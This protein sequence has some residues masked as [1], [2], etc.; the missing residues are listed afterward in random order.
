M[1]LFQ[2]F[3]CV[4]VMVRLC[5]GRIG[6]DVFDE[7]CRGVSS[8]DDSWQEVRSTLLLV[9]PLEFCYMGVTNLVGGAI[10]RL[11]DDWLLGA[12]GRSRSGRASVLVSAGSSRSR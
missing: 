2:E 7:S 8:G 1:N 6:V 11:G 10:V 5:L 9:G 4:H 3:C 12:A